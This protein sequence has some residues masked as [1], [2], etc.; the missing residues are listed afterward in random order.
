MQNNR[1]PTSVLTEQLA[2]NPECFNVGR[3]LSAS[4]TQRKEQEISARAQ[5]IARQYLAEKKAEREARLDN[6]FFGVMAAGLF[7]LFVFS[8]ATDMG[9]I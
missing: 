6:W 3:K 4:Y 5:A 1:I 7:I 8:G 9:V 2:K